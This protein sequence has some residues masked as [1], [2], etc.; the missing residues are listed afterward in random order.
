[1]TISILLYGLVCLVIGAASLYLSYGLWTSGTWYWA[2][3]AFPVWAA[4]KEIYQNLGGW[5]E[6]IRL[7]VLVLFF[8]LAQRWIFTKESKKYWEAKPRLVSFYR[9]LFASDPKWLRFLCLVAGG[10]VVVYHVALGPI[11]LSNEYASK[12]APFPLSFEEHFL[13]YLGYLPYTFTLYILIVLPM[14]IVIVEG[15]VTDQ[16]RVR[17]L[18]EPI[19]KVEPG[20]LASGEQVALQ[21]ESIVKSF[22][23]VREQITRIVGKYTY[24]ALLVIIYYEIEIG[25]GLILQLACWAQ[26]LNKWSAWIFIIVVL[27]YFAVTSF[28]MYAAAYDES[29]DALCNLASRALELLDKDTTDLVNKLRG[30]FESKYTILSFILSLAKS[31]SVAVAIFLLVATGTYT[32]LKNNKLIEPRRI[33]QTAI[34]WPVSPVLLAGADLL[35]LA[36]PDAAGA[37]SQQKFD[38]SPRCWQELPDKSLEWRG[39]PIVER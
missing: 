13:P 16:K 38:W 29:Q 1:M 11:L 7:V 37:Q 18:A 22:L 19:H 6:L 3:G 2:Y 10:L 4:G 20:S 9:Y 8:V 21:A 34:P 39:K 26:E 25:G 12:I 32:Y 36:P 35:T 33:V 31:G 15:I 17:G 5:R 30:D 24:M 14:F 28:R 27:P 23:D